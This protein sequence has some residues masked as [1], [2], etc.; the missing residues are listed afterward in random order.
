MRLDYIP[1]DAK[2]GNLPQL[3]AAD[4]E[5]Y[6]HVTRFARALANNPDVL[7]A[8]Q[9]Y[10]AELEESAE[11]DTRTIELIY[12]AVAQE[13]EC[14][15]CIDSHATQ[16]IERFGFDG[17]VVDDLESIDTLDDREQQIVDFAQAVAA[18]PRRAGPIVDQL[19]DDGFPDRELVGILTWIT[20]AI[21]ATTIADT[22]GI[23]PP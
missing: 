7:E 19:R 2:E 14:A 20:A 23:Q 15:Y 13:R 6:G 1:E 4:A 21:S 9:R 18:D 8:R 16:L 17:R 11:L 3:F 10:L 22:L 5:S 12:A